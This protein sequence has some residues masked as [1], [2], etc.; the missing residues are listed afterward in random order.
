MFSCFHKLQFRKKDG[1]AL[2]AAAILLTAGLLQWWLCPLT[3]SA[4]RKIENPY[5]TTRDGKGNTY[6][7]NDGKREILKLNPEGEIDARMSCMNHGDDVFSEVDEVAV[8]GEG[9]IYVLDV[10][11]NDTG[12]G[13]F[14][15]RILRFDR[16]GKFQEVVFENDYSDA[17]IMKRQIFS[18]VSMEGEIRFVNVEAA[19]GS[20]SLYRIREGMREPERIMQT[21]WEQVEN[22]QDFA[23]GSER[24]VYLTD[25]SG[26]VYQAGENGKQLLY[27]TPQDTYL[28]PF[29]VE[30]S[31]KGCVYFTDICNQEIYRIED[32]KAEVFLDAQTLSKLTGQDVAQAIL[33]TVQVRADNGA[34]VLCLAF[35]DRAGCLR[36]DTME[37]TGFDTAPYHGRFRLALAFRFGAFAV[38]GLILLY[39]LLALVKYLILAK[40]LF[41][42][43]LMLILAAAV[44]CS[45]MVVMTNMLTQ[46]RNVYIEE[47][48]DSM[49]SITQ[50][51][52]DTMNPELLKGVRYPADYG[53]ESYRRLQDFMGKLIDVSS[54]YSENMYCNLVKVEDNRCYALAYLDNSI[55]AYYPLDAGEAEEA[56][57]VYK[58]GE[59]YINDG[60]SDATGSYVYVKAPVKDEKGDVAGIVEI[61][62]VSDTLSGKVNEICVNIMVEI[63][64]MVIIAI[65]LINESMAFLKSHREWKKRRE[66]AAGKVFPVSWF[67]ILVL[68][69]FA[70]YNMPTSFL[71]V[72]MESFY[73]EALPFGRELAGSLPLTLNFMMIGVMSLA[74]AGFI[75]KLGFRTV[76][77][78][79]A[80]FSLSGDLMMALAGNY[81]MAAGGLLLNGIGCGFFMNALSILVANQKKE[82]QA[83]GF[84]VMN[85]AIL[86]GMI[87]G[88]VIGAALAE[89]LGESDMFFFSAG[90]WL[91]LAVFSVLVGR[92][93]HMQKKETE[94]KKSA[95]RFLFSGHTLGFFLL[96]LIPYTIINGFTSYFLPVFG[97]AYGLGESQTSL[98]LVMNCLVGI[99]LSGT[100][101]KVMLKAMGRFSMYLSSLLSLAAMV[102]FGYFQNLF[103]LAFVLLALGAA[104]SFGAPIR[105]IVF[106]GQKEV[107]EFGEDR[108]MGLY[109]FA[110]NAGESVGTVVFGGILNAGFS[111]GMWMLAGVSV[112]MMAAYEWRWGKRR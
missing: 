9:N 25:K 18:L 112:V 24:S 107:A 62:M 86:T 69:C 22:V 63:T 45:T 108:A 29:S 109:N 65:F 15:D 7:I 91:A 14:Q 51:A 13:L 59:R 106:C 111:V 16:N 79:G 54:K 3:P 60:K 70:A 55:G 53:N 1:A 93:F 103:M 96:M 92:A 39:Y 101:T 76:A 102:L 74:C 52:T 47:Q 17:M 50:I 49:C 90:I 98:L 11:W 19:E 105:E 68:L 30:C 8:D 100:L 34:E 66:T 61:G 58:T 36:L 46:F 110:D 38:S 2:C 43:R 78:L 85:G 71:P 80:L 37:Y 77:A 83:E 104:K 35:N 40:I 4:G 27:Q 57:N 26:G 95:L 82:E 33:E 56:R 44:G 12:L 84:S 21:P 41:K 10:I 64:L 73:E 32:G 94:K 20:F 72:Y 81:W 88:T 23:V 5:F 28:L 89:R 99:F 67:R 97:D 48:L 6:I 87:S 42:N 31:E 75:R